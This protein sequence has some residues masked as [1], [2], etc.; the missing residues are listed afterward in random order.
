MFVCFELSMKNSLPVMESL[1]SGIFIRGET[2]RVHQGG[3]AVKR[4][5]ILNDPALA[6]VCPVCEARAGMRCHVQRGVTRFDSHLE[7]K[8]RAEE[9]RIDRLKLEKTL[10]LLAARKAGGKGEDS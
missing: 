2:M 4:I 6:V 8:E 1:P 3:Q 10:S 5:E 9:R 7:R